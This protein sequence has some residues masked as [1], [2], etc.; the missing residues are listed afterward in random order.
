MSMNSL[1]VKNIVYTIIT[2]TREIKY[3]LGKED[4]T[5]SQKMPVLFKTLTENEKLCHY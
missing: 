4:K 5:N 3:K 2:N 1:I